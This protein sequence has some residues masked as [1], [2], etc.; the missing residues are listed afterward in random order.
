MEHNTGE[1]RGLFNA[2]WWGTHPVV[3]SYKRALESGQLNAAVNANKEVSILAGVRIERA[4]V[5]AP[6]E[7]E[8]MTDEELEREVRELLVQLGFLTPD[9]RSDRRH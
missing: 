2:S 7:F 3:R 1:T 9:A 5:G 4:E 8:S 6:G